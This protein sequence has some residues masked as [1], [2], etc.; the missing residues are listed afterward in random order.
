MDFD[1]KWLLVAT[2]LHPFHWLLLPKLLDFLCVALA[3]HKKWSHF[4]MIM[5]LIYVQN[6]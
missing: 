2:T 5:M 6:V 4:S 1:Q 3:L